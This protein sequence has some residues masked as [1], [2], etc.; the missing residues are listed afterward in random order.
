MANPQAARERTME[1][2]KG[3]DELED[4]ALLMA[5]LRDAA[6]IVEAY[7]RVRSHQVAELP[8]LTKSV[9][10]LLRELEI[11]ERTNQWACENPE[12]G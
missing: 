10:A 7:R 4:L 3:I 1:L 11:V 6:A 8:E 5:V 2:L 12:S 9:D